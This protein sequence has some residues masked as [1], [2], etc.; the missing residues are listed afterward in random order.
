M[1]GFQFDSLTVYLPP[2][3]GTPS[4]GPKRGEGIFYIIYTEAVLVLIQLYKNLFIIK[5]FN[6]RLVS[7]PVSVKSYTFKPLISSMNKI[8]KPSRFSLNQRMCYSILSDVNLK[9]S[10]THPSGESK[11]LQ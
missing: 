2:V 5:L 7:L 4:G 3:G 6:Y 11:F 1:I 8:L 10:A 9:G